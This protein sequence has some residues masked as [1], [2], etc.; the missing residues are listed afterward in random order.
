MYLH[1]RC[2][3]VRSRSEEAIQ[4]LRTDEAGRASC[5]PEEEVALAEEA[6]SDIGLARLTADAQA[7]DEELAA[8]RPKANAS[9]LG[10]ADRRRYARLR[11]RSAAAWRRVF[12]RNRR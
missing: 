2:T 6:N 1:I 7:I 3:P 8:L 5:W 12:A 9:R 4:A 10:S 11:D